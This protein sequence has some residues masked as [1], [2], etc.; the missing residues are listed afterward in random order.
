MASTTPTTSVVALAAVACA[1]AAC[2]SPEP[3]G[4]LASARTAVNTMDE[5]GAMRYAPVEL[6][7]AKTKLKRAEAAYESGDNDEARRLAEEALA[8]SQLA[9]AKSIATVQTKSATDLERS[10]EMLRSE[11]ERARMGR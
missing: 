8:D 7:R 10:I 1:L 6:D 5:A 11:I 3:I 9:R 2:S 4:E